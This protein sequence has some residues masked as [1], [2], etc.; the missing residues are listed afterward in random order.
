M[1]NESLAISKYRFECAKDDLEASQIA[2][3]HN[4][5]KNS[6]NRSYYAIFHAIRAVNALEK[7]DS[8]KHSGV[9]AYFNL[10]FVKTGKFDVAC[11]KIIESAFRM[12]NTADYEDF[13]I[14][15]KEEAEKQMQNASVFITKAEAYLQEMWQTN[16]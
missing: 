13:Y 6:I 14:A 15:N 5:F 9:I 4:K 11:A 1:S 3:E 7:F 12:R 8:K 10:H 16:I 2:F